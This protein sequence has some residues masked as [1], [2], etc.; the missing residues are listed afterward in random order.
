MAIARIYRG[1]GYMFSDAH[2]PELNIA[3]APASAD[4]NRQFR[5]AKITASQDLSHEGLGASWRAW[6]FSGY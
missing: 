4:F 3:E 6:A 5:M 2:E 1:I